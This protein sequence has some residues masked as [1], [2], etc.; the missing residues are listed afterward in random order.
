MGP[1]KFCMYIYSYV[2][3]TV[4]ILFQILRGLFTK[5]VLSYCF[6]FYLP[7]CIVLFRSQVILGMMPGVKCKSHCGN[8][9]VYILLLAVFFCIDTGFFPFHLT[10]SFKQLKLEDFMAGM[11]EYSLRNEWL[12]AITGEFTVRFQSS[13]YHWSSFPSLRYYHSML[14][15]PQVT[16]CNAVIWLLWRELLCGCCHW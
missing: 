2:R 3:V 6:I 12:I 7:V 11:T 1:P 9:G 4:Q 13:H 5:Q 10:P 15:P 8:K 14:S 16:K